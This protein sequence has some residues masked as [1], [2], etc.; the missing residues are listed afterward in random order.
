M[1]APGDQNRYRRSHHRIAQGSHSEPG[2]DPFPQIPQDTDH[3]SH[4]G[5]K[6]ECV[7]HILVLPRKLR[8]RNL[9]IHG[10]RYEKRF[11]NTHACFLSIPGCPASS[12]LLLLVSRV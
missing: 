3:R 7:P 12:V 4:P 9:G 2:T 8:H 5:E 11:D 6:A 10:K 1:K